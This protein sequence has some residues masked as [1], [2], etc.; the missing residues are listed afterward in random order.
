MGRFMNEKEGRDIASKG[1][2]FGLK[3]VSAIMSITDK[4]VKATCFTSLRTDIIRR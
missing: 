4:I 1:S 2:Y 3:S